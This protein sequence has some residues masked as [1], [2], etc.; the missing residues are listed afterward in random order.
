MNVRAVIALALSAA[1]VRLIPLQFLH[2]LNWDELEF[3]RATAWIG[4]GRLPYRDFW[5]H[6]TPLMWFVFAPFTWLTEGAGVDALVALRWAQIPVWIA[7]FWLTNLWMRGAGLGRFARWAAMA[8]ALCS[9]LFMI[10]AVEYRVESFGCLLVMA[11]LVLAQRGH[12]F[13]AGVVF[14]MAGFANLRLGPVL[15]VAVLLVL[16][17]TR[18]RGWPVI[19]GGFA[20]LVAWLAFFAATGSLDELVQQVWTDNLAERYARPVIGGFIHRLLVPFG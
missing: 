10:P 2:P 6:H 4:E 9:S 13:W 5:E 17:R 18:L 3:W 1:A 14:C 12:F 11:G 16:A 7:T 19:A 15:V 8:V 20:A